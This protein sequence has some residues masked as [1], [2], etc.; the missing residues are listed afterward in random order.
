[1]RQSL[2]DLIN[3]TIIYQYSLD[4]PIRKIDKTNL[5]TTKDDCYLSTND[6]D[7]VEIIY[8]SLIEYACNEFEIKPHNLQN[9]HYQA[10][11]NRIR[12]NEKHKQVT[13]IKYG[14]Y[15]EALLQVVL[16]IFYGS[17][18]LIA[19]GYFYNP[20]ENS[21]AKGY[22][23]YH[24]IENND[25]VELWF[26]EV[27][28]RE[29]FSSAVKS[30]VEGLEKAISDNYFDQNLLAIFNR[31]NDMNKQNLVF[32]AIREA[33]ESNPLI[34]ITSEAKKHNIKL[35]YPIFIIYKNTKVR[36]DDK[37]KDAIQHINSKYSKLTHSMGIQ[38]EIFFVFLPLN[39]VKSIKEEVL[40]W[41]ELK[42]PLMQ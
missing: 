23:L 34:S 22:D 31:K 42:K 20:T 38:F 1:M 32:E 41:I 13:K 36:Y 37:I 25:Q 21:E 17:E 10:L 29:S 9:L 28:F 4:C 19:K 2:I 11:Q 6:N 8:N 15:G 5:T 3:K 14:F 24:L 39:E 33:W 12:Y 30:A 7:L 18:T 16:N 26:G 27:K 40:K 35:V